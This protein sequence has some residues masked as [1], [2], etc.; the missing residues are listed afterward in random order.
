MLEALLL[1]GLGGALAIAG[2]VTGQYMQ[3]HNAQRVRAEGYAREDRY[4]L[5]RDRLEAYREY[6]VSLGAARVVMA[7]YSR[8]QDDAQLLNTLK[9]ERNKAWRAYSL[10]WLIGEEKVVKA[11]TVLL[12]MVDDVTWHGAKF[13]PDPWSDGIRA[14]VEAARS[15]LLRTSFAVGSGEVEAIDKAVA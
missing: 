1:A 12:K 9:E 5:Y 8:S 4:R 14:S 10:V 15:D 7:L 2:T 6:H 3:A 13:Q 11:A